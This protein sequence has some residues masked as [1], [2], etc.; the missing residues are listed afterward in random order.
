[1]RTI[2][3]LILVLMCSGYAF[4]APRTLKEAM[5][6][7]RTF[8]GTNAQMRHIDAAR[9][10][11]AESNDRLTRAADNTPAYYIINA[12]NNAG[13]VIVSGDDTV[14]D[15]L[16]Y[17]NKGNIDYNSLPD[18]AKYWLDFYT[19]EINNAVTYGIQKDESY[20]ETRAAKPVIAPLLGNIEWDQGDPYNLKCPVAAGKKTYTG[21]GA[22]A[23]A[24]VMKY[25]NYPQHGIG[26]K[27]YTTETYK[28]KLGADFENTYYKWDQMQPKY[29]AS[30][31]DEQKN[32][33]AELMFHCGVA[34]DMDYGPTESGAGSTS[35]YDALIK[36]FGY[37][38]NM[39]F[40]GRDY[41]TSGKWE[42]IVL[43]ELVAD[44]PI[45]YS[46]QSSRGGHAFVCDGSD[47]EGKYHF[48]WGWNGYANGYYAL[49][50]LTPGTGGIGAGA[51]TYNDQQFILCGVQPEITDEIVSGFNCMGTATANKTTYTRTGVI[52]VKYTELYNITSDFNGL[53]G[54][55]LYKGD[56]FVT[57]LNNPTETS[58]AINYGWSDISI[59]GSVPASVPNG[60][61]QLH[62][63]TQNKG[64]KTPS[65]MLGMEKTVVFFNVEVTDN[66][67]ILSKPTSNVDIMQAAPAEIVGICEVGS[68]ITFK[69]QVQ[70]NGMSYEDEFGIFIGKPGDRLGLTK[71][72]ISEYVT[73]PGGTT[74]TITVTG[75]PG[76]PAGEYYAIGSYKSG[77]NW[78]EFG[79]SKLRLTFTIAEEGT[80][81]KDIVDDTNSSKRIYTVGGQY[82]GTDLNVLGKGIYIVNG[83]KV[84]K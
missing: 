49:S 67:V 21:C 50:A 57:F 80:G 41:T 23:L 9:L 29:S 75:D 65:K 76:L 54:L 13:F 3:S 17:S 53:C 11:V 48:N 33:V 25:H 45:L 55:A 32:A 70:N 69:L 5:Q 6:I 40:R 66:S 26:D 16:A 59:K 34:M 64:E 14:R 51:G 20:I 7:A 24:M 4:A 71:A 31:T 18:N 44:R 78:T 84:V 74:S 79:N 37:N 10:R 63:A 52:T 22:T 43:Q 36:Y 62:L 47:G 60:T 38:P 46:G 42:S 39:Y 8:I 81:I 72:R 56:E 82:V 15:I 77:G 73:L 1:M 2:I 28:L 27:D 35:Q 19:E 68:D 58:K 30:S 83:K 12:D 61:Y